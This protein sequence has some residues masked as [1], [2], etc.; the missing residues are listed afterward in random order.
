MVNYTITYYYDDDNR[1]ENHNWTTNLEAFNNEAEL[2]ESIL[3]KLKEY[4]SDYNFKQEG[5]KYNTEN[6][7]F[8]DH[9]YITENK[10]NDDVFEFL[11]ECAEDGVDYEIL[12][13]YCS[14]FNLD[15]LSV[16]TILDYY[17]GYWKDHEEFIREFMVA[18][19]CE[20]DIPDWLRIDYK[21]TW[22]EDL[23]YHYKEKNNHYFNAN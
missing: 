6:N 1:Y 22:K 12:E 2:I 4:D 5:I 8:Y 10:I 9:G 15:E 21:R 18:E 23:Q 7:I 14:L 20:T 11:Y 13:A 3:S 19:V 17:C 16:D